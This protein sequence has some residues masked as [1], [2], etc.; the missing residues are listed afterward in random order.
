MKRICI[1][2]VTGSIGMNTVI[3]CKN[4]GYEIV[5]VTC[6]KN[7]SELSRIYNDADITDH[8]KYI[9]ICDES[10]A[11]NFI[12]M[13]NNLIAHVFRGKD[14][15]IK[16][17]L[18]CGADIIV[19]ALVGSDGI[20]PSY[21]ALE[22]CKRLALANKETVVAAGDLILGRAKKLGCEIIPI[23]SEHGAILQCLEENKIKKI[24]LTASG[25]PFREYSIEMLKNVTLNDA[26]NHP[27]WK[28]GKKITIDSATLM[29]KGFEV[30]EASKLYAL[31]YDRI[32]VVIHPESII[33][34]MVEYE[35]NSFKAQ[36][37]SCD[38]KIA[39]Q[40][41][42]T[43]PKRIQNDFEELDIT[44]YSLTFFKPDMVKF[45]CLK[46]AFDAVKNGGTL[47]TVINGANDVC[48]DKFLSGEISFLA[49]AET[50]EKVLNSY[51]NRDAEDIDDIIEIDRWA[52]KYAYDTKEI[53]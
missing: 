52:K 46:L 26:L 12:G 9:G 51:K 34:S 33:H 53:S 42:L 45:K 39:I 41:A 18:N 21:Y 35:D 16:C 29:N 37:S 40:Y 27:N 23:D 43:Y 20:E 30:I 32:N 8:I 24:H 49:I 5:A 13:N 31:P 3:V 44:N 11:D 28:M 4:L 1:L 17:I 10:S 22:N 36:L 6:N 15:N 48:V 7:Y 38:M 14:A 2:G 47:G 50:L 19:N 25:G